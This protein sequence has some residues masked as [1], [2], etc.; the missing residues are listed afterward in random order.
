MFARI[1]WHLV[2]W[3]VLVVALIVGVLGTVLYLGTS[4]NVLEQLDRDLSARAEQAALNFRAV[5]ARTREGGGTGLGLA[6]AK[7]LVDA[8]GGELSA[9]SAP[10]QG[11]RMAVRLPTE[12][13]PPS[14]P[15][16]VGAP[17][18]RITQRS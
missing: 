15:D 13:P 11:T 8:H 10:G 2:G 3:N 7:T 17:A 5:A 9:E 4:R 14:L 18:A 6:I 16:R 12:P 1:R